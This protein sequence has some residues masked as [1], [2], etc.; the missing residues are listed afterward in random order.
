M[1]TRVLETSPYRHF[2]GALLSV[3]PGSAENR[4]DQPDGTRSG[5]MPGGPS[6]YDR[7]D[8]PAKGSFGRLW[9]RLVIALEGP[10]DELIASERADLYTAADELDS[11]IARVTGF[12]PIVDDM[13]PKVPY[14]KPPD[15][16]TR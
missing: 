15:R 5:G 10:P 16:R 8:E 14:A 6:H 1:D 3:L 2:A 12:T 9:H 11:A 4:Q 13:F 7:S